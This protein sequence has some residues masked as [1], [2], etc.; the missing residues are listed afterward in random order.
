[1]SPVQEFMDAPHVATGEAQPEVAA[2]FDPPYFQWWNAQTVTR[3]GKQLSCYQGWE[4]SLDAIKNR[5]MQSG[6]FD[7]VLG[8][9]QVLPMLP[10]PQPP[11]EVYPRGNTVFDTHVLH[12]D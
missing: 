2:F 11:V 6:P 5:M 8:F 3:H 4:V 10:A 9:S 1:M 7:G 12:R